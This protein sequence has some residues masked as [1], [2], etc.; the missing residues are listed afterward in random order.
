MYI[1]FTLTC[2]CYAVIA[3]CVMHMTRHVQP[4]LVL[5]PQCTPHTLAVRWRSPLVPLP[6]AASLHAHSDQTCR[7]GGEDQTSQIDHTRMHRASSTPQW[8]W[9]HKLKHNTQLMSG[10][11]ALASSRD[12]HTSSV[13]TAR[14]GC[15]CFLATCC[16]F[17]PPPVNS[18]CPE[19]QVC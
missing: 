10:T 11:L 16:L 1:V 18:K 13:L 7:Q 12:R 17:F 14:R 15:Q 6:P 9:E 3:Q 8:Q 5:Y 2:M 4:I 19:Y